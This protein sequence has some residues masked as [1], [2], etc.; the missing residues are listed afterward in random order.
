MSWMLAFSRRTL[1][2]I[3]TIV[4]AL[5]L[6]TVSERAYAQSECD[7]PKR[8]SQIN[9][10][11]VGVEWGRNYT[12]A[13]IGGSTQ[14]HNDG[15]YNG[16]LL[17]GQA[18]QQSASGP[19]VT[20]TQYQ[21]SNPLSAD[22]K[23]Y[24]MP[25]AG[26]YAGFFEN[27]PNSGGCYGTM[28]TTYTG[29]RANGGTMRLAGQIPNWVDVTRVVV[30]ELG[31]FFGLDNDN[32]STMY[33]QTV[34]REFDTYQDY[35]HMTVHHPWQPSACDMAT[36]SEGAHH[37][38]ADLLADPCHGGACGVNAYAGGICRWGN[39][40]RN[41]FCWP[42]FY[43]EPLKGDPSFRF[44][45]RFRLPTGL[46]LTTGAVPASGSIRLGAIDPDGKVMRVDWYVNGSHVYTALEDPFELPYANMAPGPYTVKANIWGYVE[47]T[48]FTPEVT[49]TVQPNG[50]VTSVVSFQA[51]S[52][53]AF[54]AAESGGGSHLVANR[55]SAGAW[56]HFQLEPQPGGG[57]A[58]RAD[59]GLLVAA[60]LGGNDEVNANRT[61]VGPWETFFLEE[62][63]GG[64]VAIRTWNGHYLRAD[65]VAGGR[66]DG[67]GAP[68]TPGPWE[69]FLKY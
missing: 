56:E 2:P 1:C 57:V 23:I 63:G 45:M 25:T 66:L 22:I 68:G 32:R 55:A 24:L 64:W 47:D 19:Q 50:P 26:P 20:F 44:D 9:G 60:E 17:W 46:V 41:G 27:C 11:N 51:Y 65:P 7:T 36:A 49:I 37:R 58:I 67:R 18:S 40:P 28:Q 31:H 5:V 4:A 10:R 34:M 43:P 12:Y 42:P 33:G 59:N 3:S 53:S 52:T 54:V 39:A 29:A 69:L 14:A 35:E 21:G 13:I 8:L 15:V 30:H 6:T 62:L 16:M 61:S 38:R 48:Q